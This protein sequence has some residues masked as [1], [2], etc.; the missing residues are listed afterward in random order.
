MTPAPPLLVKINATLGFTQAFNAGYENMWQSLFT[1]CELFHNIALKLRA[2]SK[3]LFNMLP[4]CIKK[5]K[6]DFKM[7]RSYPSDISREQ[8]SKIE[9]TL[10]SARKIT[11]PRELDLYD[12]FCAI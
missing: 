11:R 4:L 1:M 12:V 2:C 8:F 9:P 5:H 6:K 10:L 7:R 3:S